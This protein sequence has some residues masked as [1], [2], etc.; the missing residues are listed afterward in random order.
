MQRLV[1]SQISRS[2]KQVLKLFPAPKRQPVSVVQIQSNVR[3]P[4]D[5]APASPA[6][7]PKSRQSLVPTRLPAIAVVTTRTVP[8]LL[9]SALVRAAL[10]RLF[11]PSDFTRSRYLNDSNISSPDYSKNTQLGP[12]NLSDFIHPF[13]FNVSVRFGSVSTLGFISTCITTRS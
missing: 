3:V 10:N 9:A 12:C 5:T 2:R 1:V 7:R 11:V 4:L 6:L 8:V 13:S